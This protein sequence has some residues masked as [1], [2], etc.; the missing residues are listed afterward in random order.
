[1]SSMNLYVGNLSYHTTESG[2][3]DL[4][5]AYGEVTSAKIIMDRE[6]GRSKGFGFVEMANR[7]EGERAMAELNGREVDQRPL[8]VNEARPRTNNR[9]SDGFGGGGGRRNYDRY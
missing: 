5:A 8:K 9:S 1:M 6:S 7:S 3:R 4:F 2:L